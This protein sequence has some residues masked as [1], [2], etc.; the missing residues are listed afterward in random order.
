MDLKRC[1]CPPHVYYLFVD[2]Q[3]GV[4]SCGIEFGRYADMSDA[5]LHGILLY[6]A[7][8]IEYGF[9]LHGQCELLNV[10]SHNYCM[11]ASKDV[12]KSFKEAVEFT[13]KFLDMP[14]RSTVE[15]GD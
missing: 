6:H 10:I 4:A 13:N 1:I 7:F 12:T 11:G 5:L 2:R 9:G 8:I 14:P 3:Y 15:Y